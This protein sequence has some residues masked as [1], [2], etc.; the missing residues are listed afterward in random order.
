MLKSCF[1]KSLVMSATIIFTGSSGG[2]V[3][4][5][6]QWHM[7]CEDEDPQASIPYPQAL[8]AQEEGNIRNEEG[9]PAHNASQSSV[10]SRLPQQRFVVPVMESST[11]CSTSNSSS[12]IGLRSVLQNSYLGSQSF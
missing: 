2:A 3:G 5:V 9:D 4:F 12:S 6:D 10:E 1:Y 11:R 7:V 8:V